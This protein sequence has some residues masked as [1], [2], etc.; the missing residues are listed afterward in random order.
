MKFKSKQKRELSIES[1]EG[2][3]GEIKERPG[4][5][6]VVRVSAP[7]RKLPEAPNGGPRKMTVELLVPDEQSAKHAVEA[8][9]KLAADLEAS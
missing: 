7:L 8:I 3:T 6:F 9:A 1:D 4:G 5:N 2:V